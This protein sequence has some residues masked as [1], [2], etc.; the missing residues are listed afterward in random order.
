MNHYKKDK[1]DQHDKYDKRDDYDKPGKKDKP[2]KPGKHD[3]YDK[4]GKHDGKGN[5]ITVDLKATQI[6]PHAPEYQKMF[7][8]MQGNILKGHGR[9]Y[10][11]HIFLKFTADAGA[12]QKWIESF[13]KKYVTSAEQQLRD[14]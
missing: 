10:S 11:A 1:H 4:P 5:V 9:D 12:I 6:N 14:T 7:K 2:D 8:N 13:A 3:D